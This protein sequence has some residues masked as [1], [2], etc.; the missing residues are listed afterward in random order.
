MNIDNHH[1]RLFA[2]SPERVAELLAD[3]GGVWPTELAPA[4]VEHHGGALRVGPMLWQE[5]ERPGAVRAFRVVAP[6]DLQAEHWFEVAPQDGGSILRHRV[7][8]RAVGEFARVWLERMQPLHDRILE[9]LLD[10][11]ERLAA[12]DARLVVSADELRREL[13]QP[14]DRVRGK[15]R[16]HL[17]ARAAAFIARSP[18]LVM[19][20]ASSSGP[21]DA[22]PKGGP[23]GFVRVVDE[24]RLL[25]PEFWGNRRFDGVK[26]LSERNGVGLLFLVPGIT[27]TLRVNGTAQVTRE[28]ALIDVW[29]AEGR[30]PWFVV[31]VAVQEVY[32]HCSKAFLRSGAWE[33]E[34]WPD[35]NDVISPSRTIAERASAEQRPEGDI[36]REVDADYSSQLY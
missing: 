28:A 20:T 13:G 24:R 2:A 14:S 17:D 1:E 33:P 11:V 36:R 23:P 15:E 22:S 35:P 16:G 12:S 34:R 32:S 4:P 19:A 9:G 10:N 26:N 5:I 29:A 31:D 8:G 21:A 25:I 6:G 7:V 18:L 27:E 3:L 30:P